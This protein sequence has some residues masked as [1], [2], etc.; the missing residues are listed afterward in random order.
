MKYI[1]LIIMAVALL[2]CEVNPSK[3]GAGEA[4][5]FAEKLTYVKDVRTQL[6]F[7]IVATRPTGN[8]DQSGMGITEVP[9]FNVEHLIGK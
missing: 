3:V 5:I 8:T 7:A 2:G 4:R 6:C 1:I 9:C